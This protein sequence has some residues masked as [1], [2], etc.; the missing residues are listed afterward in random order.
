MSNKRIRGT[1]SQQHKT[2]Q[3]GTA[4]LPGHILFCTV[5]L[6]AGWWKWNA[7]KLLVFFFFLS[8]FFFLLV[9][10]KIIHMNPPHTWLL[11]PRTAKERDRQGEEGLSCWNCLPSS[12]L[13]ASYKYNLKNSKELEDIITKKKKKVPQCARTYTKKKTYKKRWSTSC[14]VFTIRMNIPQR[15]TTKICT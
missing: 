2:T 12:G 1:F 7:W 4:F 10:A 13:L 15:Q 6:H 9:F 11:N 14:R 8:F 5:G 3:A